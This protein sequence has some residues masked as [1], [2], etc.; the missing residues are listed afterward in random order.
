MKTDRIVNIVIIATM[1]VLTSVSRSAVSAPPEMVTI[2]L[3]KIGVA[4]D[5]PKGFGIFEMTD[6]LHYSI[7]TG[8][9]FGNE[10]SPGHL[11]YVP[12]LTMGFWPTGHDGMRILS[13]YRPSQYI[14]VEFERVKTLNPEY[15]KLVGNKG[16][17]YNWHGL[18]GYTSI[19]GYRTASKDV[20]EYLIRIT[21]TRNAG[22]AVELLFN[23]VLSSLRVFK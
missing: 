15:V 6:S 8:I 13:E 9:Q 18:D 11:N 3:E 4:F 21:V 10:L 12:G 16:V 5:I 17:R 14:D 7:G 19:V 20:P 22:P 23:S 2:S 1:V